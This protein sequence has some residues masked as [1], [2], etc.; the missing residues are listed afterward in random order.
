M[1]YVVPP[2]GPVVNGVA[3]GVSIALVVLVVLIVVILAVVC[4]MVP[5]FR[6]KMRQLFGK[7]T[8]KRWKNGNREMTMNQVEFV[9]EKYTQVIVPVELDNNHP[10][11][12]GEPVIASDHPTSQSQ[13]KVRMYK[14]TIMKLFCQYKSNELVL[15][16]IL[17]IQLYNVSYGTV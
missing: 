8:S 12:G 11:D 9:T 15:S 6:R 2:S 14:E 13:E 4:I 1:C 3:V 7:V 16:I 10:E 5:R 17:I